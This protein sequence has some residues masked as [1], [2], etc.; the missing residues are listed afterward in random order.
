[1]RL[2]ERVRN[3]AARLRQRR[4]RMRPHRSDGA[5][6]VIGGSPRSGT[7][8]L[9]R[10]LDRHLAIACG[11]EMGLFLPYPLRLEPLSVLSGIEIPTLRAMLRASASQ[12][13]FVDAF[14]AAYLAAGGKERW[15]EKSPQNILELDWILERFPRARVIHVIRDGRDVVCSARTHG[16]RRWREGQWVW[17]PDERPVE[18]HAREWVRHTGAGMRRRGDPRVHELRYE[19]LVSAPEETLERL[20]TFLGVPFEPAMLVD[21]AVGAGEGPPDRGPISDRSI[22]RWMRDLD[23]GEQRRVQ[24]ICA[25]RL[26][27]LGYPV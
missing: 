14:A 19:D 3:R 18:W 27:E 23:A 8:L 16:E 15:A 20:C 21:P 5:W 10:I 24:E 12:G 26:R 25:D 13:A 1:M 9:R 11:P 7:T 22:G 2:L 17:T 6:I 4:W